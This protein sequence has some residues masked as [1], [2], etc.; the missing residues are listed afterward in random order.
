MDYT[1]SLD[2]I[3]HINAIAILSVYLI[4]AAWQDYTTLT[5]PIEAAWLPYVICALDIFVRLSTEQIIGRFISALIIFGIFYFMA[6]FFPG[7]GGDALVVP[8]IGLMLGLWYSM[9]TILLAC[10][11]SVFFILGRRLSHNNDS[12]NMSTAI[13]FI[14][15]ISIAFFCV[16]L[17]RLFVAFAA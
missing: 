12:A 16:Y 11:I 14:P 4:F 17:G 2:I 6:K 5:V 7:G 13:P 1:L 8:L 15:G 3:L 10:F 9:I